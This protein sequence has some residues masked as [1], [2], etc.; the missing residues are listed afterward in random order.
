MDIAV[1]GAGVNLVL[2]AVGDLASAATDPQRLVYN[3]ANFMLAVTKLAQTNLRNV[4]GDMQ[5]DE[6]LTSRDKINTELREINEAALRLSAGSTAP[7]VLVLPD[8][9]YP[10]DPADLFLVI[11]ED[12]VVN[13]RFARLARASV[14]GVHPRERL[15]FKCEMLY[16]VPRPCALL[17]ALVESA[18][19]TIAAAVRFERRHQFHHS[20]VEPVEL[21]GRPIFVPTYVEA[22]GSFVADEFSD[23][24]PL[25]PGR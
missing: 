17:H 4:I 3:V 7:V 21:V 6:A 19:L 9:W 16:D 8:D 25:S 24:A 14:S 13:A 15:H 18:R 5:L 2:D 10:Q 11:A 23:V 1:A 20:L 12:D 22:T